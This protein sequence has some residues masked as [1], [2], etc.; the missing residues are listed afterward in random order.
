MKKTIALALAVLLAL[1][2]LSGCGADD[3]AVSGNAELPEEATLQ[4]S[5]AADPDLGSSEALSR[6]FEGVS[7]RPVFT[8]TSD[9]AGVAPGGTF[10]VAYHVKDAKKVACFNLVVPFDDAL[11]LVEMNTCDVKDLHFE[12]NNTAR[13]VLFFAY[14]LE[15]VDLDDVTLLELTFKLDPSAAETEVHADLEISAFQVGVDASGVETADMPDVKVGFAI[16]VKA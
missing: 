7:E 13:G 2:A 1:F 15:T 14:T 8:V 9:C 12:S 6:A 16:P 10:K 4:K 5:A 11:E 3:P